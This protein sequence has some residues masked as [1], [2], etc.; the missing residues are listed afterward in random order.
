MVFGRLGVLNAFPKKSF[1]PGVSATER[2]SCVHQRHIKHVPSNLIHQFGSVQLLSHVRLF[3]TPMDCRTLG[4]PVHQWLQEFTQTHVHWVG[5]AI[6]PSHPLSSPSQFPENNLITKEK[7]VYWNNV[8]HPTNSRYSL[9]NW[10]L[11]NTHWSVHACVCVCVC[12]YWA[13]C[14]ARCYHSCQ[15]HRD[16]S[17]KTEPVGTWKCG[18]LT[19]VRKNSHIK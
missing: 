15:V 17:N 7:F 4:L 2:G 18:L 9:W 13:R 10:I 6:Q 8:F 12:V 14:L 5:D 16:K 1:K 3:V 19:D 11:L